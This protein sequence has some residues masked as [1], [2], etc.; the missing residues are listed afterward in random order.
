[1]ASN[2]VPLIVCISD[3]NINCN[4]A[5][6]PRIG[7]HR[8]CNRNNRGDTVAGIFIRKFPNSRLFGWIYPAIM[9]A[10]WH[11][12]PQSVLQSQFAG[13]AFS[14]VFYAL[15]LGLGWGYVAWKTGTIRH[16]T[17]AHILHDILGLSGFTFLLHT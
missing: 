4:P 5:G 12:A 1:M 7:N 6:Y 3:K 8:L 14:F 15:L 16:V 10:L 11:I 13:G 17:A 9:F 2:P